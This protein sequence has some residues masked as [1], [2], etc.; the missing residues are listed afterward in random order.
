MSPL[1]KNKLPCGFP[2]RL[3]MAN[4]WGGRPPGGL[5]MTKRF[6]TSLVTA[7]S[8]VGVLSVVGVLI[9]APTPAAAQAS[10]PAARAEW[11]RD[12]G[13]VWTPGN[14]GYCAA[15]RRGFTH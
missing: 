8:L 4:G 1:T 6:L 3:V 15:G 7:T 13:G 2:K 11:A 14:A 12:F 9:Q 5:A 10:A